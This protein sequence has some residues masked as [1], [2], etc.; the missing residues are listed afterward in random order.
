RLVGV[1]ED[2]LAVAIHFASAIRPQQ[3]VEPAVVVT[4][5]VTELEAEW[6]PPLLEQS[7]GRQQVLPVVGELGDSD[8]L[9]PIGAVHL[10]LPDVAPRQ[11]LPL[12]VHHDGGED[13][14]VPGTELLADLGGDGAALL[15]ALAEVPGTGRAGG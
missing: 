10:E 8:L 15:E 13:V 2:G 14:V 6:V 11:R 9:E 12:L 4:E 1:D 5:A 7:P 3:R